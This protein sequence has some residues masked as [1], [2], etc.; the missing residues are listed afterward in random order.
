MRILAPSTLVS[1]A[2][3]FGLVDPQGYY[4]FDTPGS[5]SKSHKGRDLKAVWQASRALWRRS[6]LTAEARAA[7]H[8]HMMLSHKKWAWVRLIEA[9]HA[10]DPIEAMQTFLAPPAVVGELI[11]RVAGHFSRAGD[12][13]RVPGEPA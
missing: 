13:V 4:A 2:L 9:K 3:W 8:D 7:V 11:S 6:G 5:L 12:S 10:R 1:N